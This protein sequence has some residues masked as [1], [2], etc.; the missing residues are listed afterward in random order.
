[1]PSEPAPAEQEP[2]ACSEEDIDVVIELCDG[3]PR[4]AIR[5]LLVA[6]AALEDQLNRAQGDAVRA[7]QGYIRAQGRRG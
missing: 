2:F 1:M 7:S 3:D 5:A 4:A 6:C